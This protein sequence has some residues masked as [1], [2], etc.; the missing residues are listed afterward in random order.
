VLY[1]LGLQVSHDLER[2]WEKIREALVEPPELPRDLIYE[3]DLVRLRQALEKRCNDVLSECTNM[4]AISNADGEGVT[5]KVQSLTKELE[6]ERQARQTAES[7]MELFRKD[8]QVL[9]KQFELTNQRVGTLIQQ[10]EEEQEA[11]GCLEQVVN[12]MIGQ[13][14]SILEGQRQVVSMVNSSQQVA[15]RKMGRMNN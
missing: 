6:S 9:K 11:R 5:G 10:V 14:A 13:C 15:S 2:L 12:D 4:L 8:H 3:A 7:E 1:S